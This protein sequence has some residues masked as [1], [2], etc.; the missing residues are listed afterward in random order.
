MTKNDIYIL[1]SGIFRGKLTLG[2]VV[3]LYGYN[4]AEQVINFDL[5]SNLVQ[6]EW[7]RRVR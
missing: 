3:R 1:A 2:L 4:V 6:S 5:R 7:K